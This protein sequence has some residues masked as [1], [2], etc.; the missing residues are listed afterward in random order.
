MNTKK[1]RSYKIKTLDKFQ[2]SF[3]LERGYTFSI[4]KTDPKNHSKILKKL[5][6][7]A[8]ILGKKFGK[9]HC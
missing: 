6:Q 5:I 2:S 4:K 8:E 3:G 7:K 9:F 1:F